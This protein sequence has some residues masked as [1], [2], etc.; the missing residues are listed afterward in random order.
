LDPA[1][2]TTI[3]PAMEEFLG[4]EEWLDV[5]DAVIVPPNSSK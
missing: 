3:K 5:L 4:K 2:L 1:D